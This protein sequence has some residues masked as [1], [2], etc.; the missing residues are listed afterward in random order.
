MKIS[1]TNVQ[2]RYAETDQMGVVY[3]ANYLIWC[4]MGRTQLINDLGFRYQDM[5]E[6]GI[7]APVTN[8]NLSYKHPAK[9]GETILVKT[10]IEQYTGVQTTYGYEITNQNG[11]VCAFGTTD[12]VC[13]KKD[14][15][16]PVPLRRVFPDWHEVYEANK[17]VTT[18]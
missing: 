17:K 16:R 14:S 4:E 5:E 12:H 6:S 11:D 9:Y 15:F 2:V 7:L 18:S 1:T 10:W 13:V 3:H 8:V